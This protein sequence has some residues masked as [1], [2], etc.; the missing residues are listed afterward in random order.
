M[1]KFNNI[2][3]KE[4]KMLK[5]MFLSS[6]VMEHSY[7]Y[8]RQ[9][10]LG[11]SL[12]MWPVIKEVYK[13]KEEQ[14]DALERHMCVFNATPHIETLIMGIAAAM[15]KEASQNPN[16]DKSSINSVKVGLMGPLSGIGDSIFWGSLRVVAAGVGL[17][18]CQQGNPLGALVFLLLYN[19][20][21]LIIKYYC[22]FIG[23][24]FGLDL[25]TNVKNS[26]ILDKITKAATIVG[27]MVIGGMTASMV[28]LTLSGEF[29]ISDNVFIIQ[30][31]IDQIFPMLLPLLYTLFMYYLVQIKKC[32]ATTLLIIS[33]IAS[34]ALVYL[35]LA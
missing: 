26:G 16:F 8:E 28:T 9:Q 5:K 17:A 27:L 10:G 1:N 33:I 22:T 3:P 15:E 11:F 29:A 31:Y 21:H 25:M 34:F 18:L 35:G 19:I 32:K 12:G 20:P 7:N 2:S 6:F 23:Y 13:T 4:K 14:G 30:D 24:S